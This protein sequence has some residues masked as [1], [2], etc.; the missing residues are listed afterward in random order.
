MNAISFDRVTKSFRS[1]RPRGLKDRL[2]SSKGT[3][4]QSQRVTVLREASFSVAPGES[5]SIL[6]HNG[7]GKSTIL[8]TISGLVKPTAGSVLLD[9]QPVD[10]VS[11]ENRVRAG[12]VHVPERRRIF[13]GLTVLDWTR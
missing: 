2:L 13:P 9:G 5:V 1:G 8:R 10:R 11:P 7:A 6:G 12:L 3:R 4:P